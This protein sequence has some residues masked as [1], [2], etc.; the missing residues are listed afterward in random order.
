MAPR[1]TVLLK[2]GK[3]RSLLR[4]HPWVYANAVERVER[5]PANGALV[6]VCGAD[7]RF[8]AWGAYSPGSL[9]RV[10]CWSFDESARIDEA[11]LTTRVE[12]ALARRAPLAGDTDALRL[13]F[14]EAD[15][16]PGLIVDRY[17]DT[18]VIQVQAAGVDAWRAVLIDALCRT[19]GCRDVFDRS[20][21]ALREREGLAPGGGVLRGSTPPARIDIREHGVAYHVDVRRGHKTGFY[22][23]QRDNRKFAADWVARRV[24]AVGGRAPRVLNCFS[25]TGGFSIAAARAGAASV[26]SIDSS[27]DALA[28]GQANAALNGL[29]P[30]ATGAGA[31]HAPPPV[32]GAPALAWHCAD[33]FEELRRLR[34]AGERF[35]LIILDP[36]KFA[37]NQH[38]IERAARAYKDINLSALRLL[39]P[40]GLLMS[41]SCSGAVDAELF[42]KIVA[43]AVIDA[44]VDCQL[45]ARLGAGADHPTLMTHPEGEYLKGLALERR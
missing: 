11:W 35:D 39:E 40:A 36:P 14:G 22:L 16:L 29:A 1:A 34:D 3:E 20:D 42:R 30:A 41:F 31:A 33:V 45:L 27:A 17:A 23:D 43:G 44:G 24:R 12:Q 28:L 13:V 21:A 32:A 26:I 4:R 37:T 6:A 7:R 18:L 10:R 5:E 25:Y 9:I 15:G 19:T 8:L 2:A 38:Q